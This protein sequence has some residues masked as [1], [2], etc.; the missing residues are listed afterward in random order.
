MS[1]T[2]V[3]LTQTGWVQYYTNIYN[4]WILQIY[5]K[6]I[7]T[8]VVHSYISCDLDTAVCYLNSNNKSRIEK[9]GPAQNF[10]VK[11]FQS[12]KLKTIYNL[13]KAFRRFVDFLF[14]YLGWTIDR[15]KWFSI[16]CHQQP[17]QS[18]THSFIKQTSF[19]HNNYCT[20]LAF[21]ILKLST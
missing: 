2:G 16:I 19:H 20:M 10:K 13:C 1:H 14:C 6:Y 21:Q 4:V 12:I 8:R 5:N 7:M 18:R 17:H 9:Y 3:W 15:K 11:N